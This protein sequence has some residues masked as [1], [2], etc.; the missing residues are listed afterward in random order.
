MEHHETC[1]PDLT[2]DLAVTGLVPP[3]AVAQSGDNGKPRTV[4]PSRNVSPVV[5]IT[6]FSL[7]SELI[8]R[9]RQVPVVV[10]IASPVDPSAS[11]LRRDLVARA[12]DAGLRWILGTV[13]ADR[14]PQVVA[15]FRPQS[16]PVVTVVADGTGVAA[17]TPADAVGTGGVDCG[18][19]VTT[20]VDRVA[21]RLTGLPADTVVEQGGES[22][23]GESGATDLTSDPRMAEAARLVGEGRP[24]EAVAVYDRMLAADPEPAAKKVLDRARAAVAV[25]D[26]TSD[27]DRPAVLA[28]VADARGG[29]TVGTPRL[30]R[31]AD[32]LVLLDRPAAAVDLLSAALRPGAAD[33]GEL[34]VRVIELCHLL[35]QDAPA[36]ERARRRIAS[37]LF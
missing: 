35:E 3:D 37:A 28:A 4:E 32:V 18:D 26:R 17:W 20:V 14:F 30:L 21:P 23:T 36:A 2:R 1:S 31:A 7:E 22:G 33:L 25:L 16:L 34:R 6:P 12:G 13:D 29:A 27:M 5:D 19:W 15:E 8:A 10:L 11:L 9:S 24:G